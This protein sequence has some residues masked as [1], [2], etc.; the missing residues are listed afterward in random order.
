M[1]ECQIVWW[2]GNACNRTQVD[3]KPLTEE[4]CKSKE[5]E[6]TRQ[7]GNGIKIELEECEHWRIT[8]HDDGDGDGDGDEVEI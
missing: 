1:S 8:A 7:A 2:E 3:K 6:K 5:G 4:G